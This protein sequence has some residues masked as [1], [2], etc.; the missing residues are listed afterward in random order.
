M[1]SAREIVRIVACLLV[2]QAKGDYKVAAKSFD[3][4]TQTFFPEENIS[5]VDRFLRYWHKE[6]VAREWDVAT[7]PG[8]GRKPTIP[9][10]VIRKAAPWVLHKY[11]SN[12]K[13]RHY[14]SISEVRSGAPSAACR[15]SLAP[16]LLTLDA[17]WHWKERRIAT[18]AGMG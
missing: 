16:H 6:C 1:T 11:F 7:K 18:P 17:C 13:G 8:R 9:D 5:R 3:E 12:G 14:H 10:D 15:T 4:F 2:I